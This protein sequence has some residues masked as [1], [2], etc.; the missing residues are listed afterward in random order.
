MPKMFERRTTVQVKRHEIEVQ[1]VPALFDE[2]KHRY[3]AAVRMPVTGRYRERAA[4]EFKDGKTGEDRQL[5][6]CEEFDR[7]TLDL[8][9]RPEALADI[10][11]CS[12]GTVFL[13][14]G[15]DPKAMKTAVGG[16]RLARMEY[17]RT[18]LWDTWVWL[19]AMVGLLSVEWVVRRLRGLA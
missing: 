7:E 2:Q 14:Q 12:G 3:L 9:A 17:R 5:L 6:A 4:A 19:T 18:P 15:N 8:R 16:S 13:A 11:R 1:R 10:S